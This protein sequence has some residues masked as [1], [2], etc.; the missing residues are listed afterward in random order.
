MSVYC[1]YCSECGDVLNISA[2]KTDV[3][4]R[5]VLYIDPCE[6]CL[7]EFEINKDDSTT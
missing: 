5:I 3:E 1:I 6:K 4:G 2:R 7:R